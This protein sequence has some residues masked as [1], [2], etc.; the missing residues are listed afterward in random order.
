MTLPSRKA[1]VSSDGGGTADGWIED[2]VLPRVFFAVQYGT[3][4]YFPPARCAFAIIHRGTVPFERVRLCPGF[5][6]GKPV[7]VAAHSA[8]AGSK[9]LFAVTLDAPAPNSI[10]RARLAIPAASPRRIVPFTSRPKKFR[11]A[12]FSKP[13]D[14]AGQRL[15]LGV[16]LPPLVRPATVCPPTVCTNWCA[17]DRFQADPGF[18]D[19]AVRRVRN[20]V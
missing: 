15:E 12:R 19:L 20:L 3:Q 18:L 10:G 2:V 8:S 5:T 13:A 7:I 6:A 16:C 9:D 11:T 14:L 17:V 4:V 1:H